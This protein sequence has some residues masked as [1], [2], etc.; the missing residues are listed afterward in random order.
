MSATVLCI[1]EDR[2]VARIHAEVLEA[3]GDEVVCAFD[4]RQ[5]LEI[6]RMRTPDFAVIDAS[7]PLQ[8]GF[9]ILAEMRGAKPAVGCRS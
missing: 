8:N 1:H 7:L 2:T 4:G 6:A 9:E 3:E 5:G